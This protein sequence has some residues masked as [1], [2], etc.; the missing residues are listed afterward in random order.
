M[1][2]FSES[3]ELQDI[4]KRVRRLYGMNRINVVQH[5]VAIHYVKQLRRVFSDPAFAS[6]K[7]VEVSRAETHIVDAATR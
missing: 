3:K 6:A 4:E 1:Q 5:N 7:A 2:N